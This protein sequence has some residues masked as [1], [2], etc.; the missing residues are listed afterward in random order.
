MPS[1]LLDV[2]YELS[3]LHLLKSLKPQYFAMQIHH[4]ITTAE[5]EKQNEN[6][7]HALNLISCHSIA[8]ARNYIIAQHSAN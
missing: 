4:A 6:Q 8:L 3:Q 5:H 1:N 2:S 7:G